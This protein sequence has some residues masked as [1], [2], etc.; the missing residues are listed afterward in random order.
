MAAELKK[1]C[2]SAPG[3]LI[4][5]GEHSVVYGKPAVA[6]S[7]DLRTATEVSRGTAGKVGSL[8]L[9]S[10]PLHATSSLRSTQL[11]LS[12]PLPRPMRPRPIISHRPL[13]I[14]PH[15]ES[16]TPVNLGLMCAVLPSWVVPQ[17][18][19]LSHE[20]A[21]TPH[22]PTPYRT[23]ICVHAVAQYGTCSLV[24]TR[25][26]FPLWQVS[27]ELPDLGIS[28]SWT[29]DDLQSVVDAASTAGDAADGHDETA[30]FEAVRQ[31]AGVGNAETEAKS[32]GAV[33]FLHLYL[34][35]ACRPTKTVPSAAV[36]VI[37]QL[38]VGAGLGSSAA[39]SVAL[40][41]GLLEAVG[42]IERKEDGGYTDEHRKLINTWAFEG[43]KVIHGT[44][45][46][47]DNAVSSFGGAIHFVKG[48]EP[49]QLS[50]VPQLRILL[51]NTKIPR[52][53]MALVAG[54]R[55]LV[56]SFPKVM[57]PLLDAMGELSLEVEQVL[58]T[59][60]KEENDHRAWTP[61]SAT[62]FEVRS[63][64]LLFDVF[65]AYLLT[66]CMAAH[67]AHLVLGGASA[68]WLQALVDLNQHLLRTIG[69]GHT[70]LDEV[71]AIASS[72]KAHA[73]LTGAG[74]GGC[75]FVVLPQG[76][77]KAEL[78]V[79]TAA[80]EAKGFEVWETTVGG[81]GVCGHPGLPFGEAAASLLV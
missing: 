1:V 33:A 32:L 2:V 64:A 71:C 68:W 77:E 9:L 42:S 61:G 60:A 81:H 31:L 40:A 62:K 80:F 7:L 75:A 72:H 4:L 57:N 23:R 22:P 8:H 39:Y 28:T 3:K 18:H 34:K 56:T 37:S 54:V 25:R 17:K 69:V 24:L 53:T 58:A 67:L 47:I 19:R 11:Q 73:K 38:P 51:V 12:L 36:R 79:M 6:A 29:V 78:G 41:A 27:L 26:S 43:E 65:A 66:L 55:E 44:P 21:P 13:S 52:S 46:G 35:I 49:V 74:G 5:T 59:L 63:G 45:S 48:K 20:I 10:S 50:A 15:P 30:H 70:A 76:I 14:H 16:F